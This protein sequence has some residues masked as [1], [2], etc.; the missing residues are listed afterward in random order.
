MIDP[1]RSQWPMD[2]QNLQEWCHLGGLVRRLEL[3]EIESI[4]NV[5]WKEWCTS[6]RR[7]GSYTRVLQDDIFCFLAQQS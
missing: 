2:T 5:Q 1:E 4:T 3:P 7:S 6:P